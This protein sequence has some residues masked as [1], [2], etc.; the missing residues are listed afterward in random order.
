[1]NQL[2]EQGK[3]L[4]VAAATTELVARI[5]AL[6]SHARIIPRDVPWSDEEISLEVTLTLS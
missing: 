1:M 4:Q 6:F 2:V 3:S 5:L